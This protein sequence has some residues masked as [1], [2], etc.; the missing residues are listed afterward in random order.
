MSIRTVINEVSRLVAAQL[1]KLTLA[2]TA[3]WSWLSESGL[4]LGSDP[5]LSRSHRIKL[6]T[7]ILSTF[8]AQPTTLMPCWTSARAT[9]API[10]TEAPVTRATLPF[11][12]SMSRV[13]STVVPLTAAHFGILVFRMRDAWSVPHPEPLRS[14]PCAPLGCGNV[15]F[16]SPPTLF[17]SPEPRSSPVCG[18][19]PPPAV[20]TG[21]STPLSGFKGRFRS[22]TVRPIFKKMSHWNKNV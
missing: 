18:H 17:P 11:H 20:R 15:C 10:P 22:H 4:G 6:P 3:S 1:L 7:S 19:L 8:L 12:R 14:D 13:S 21:N 9:A 5:L 16:T 2:R